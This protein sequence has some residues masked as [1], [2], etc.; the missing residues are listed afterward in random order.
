MK[1]HTISIDGQDTV[2]IDSQPVPMDMTV[3]T[4]GTLHSLLIDGGTKQVLVR[5][6]GPALGD[7]GVADHIEDPHLRVVRT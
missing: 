2:T 1:P 6:I 7:F 3:S 4:E 5:A